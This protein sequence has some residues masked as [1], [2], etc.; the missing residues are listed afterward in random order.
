MF[1]VAGAL[2]FRKNN[3]FSTKLPRLADLDLKVVSD[4]VPVSCFLET[5]YRD[6]DVFTTKTLIKFNEN[7]YF[8]KIDLTFR[9]IKLKETNY[10]HTLITSP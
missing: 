4:N 9:K 7:H 8:C 1:F 5:I 2:I 10:E 3:D 6:K